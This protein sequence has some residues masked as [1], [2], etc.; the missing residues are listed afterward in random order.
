MASKPL[1][2]QRVTDETARGPEPIRMG[3]ELRGADLEGSEMQRSSNSNMCTPPPAW[4]LGAAALLGVALAVAGCGGSSSAGVAHLSSTKGAPSASS[5]GGGTSPDST[6]SPQQAGLAFSKCMRSNGVPS[7]PDP[8]PGGGLSLPAG[9]NP[10]APAFRAAQAKCAK[11]IPGGG[12]PG[13][14]STTHPSAQ[15]LARFL[16]VARCMRQ[17]G[18]Y[19]FPEPRTSVPA[20]PFGSGGGGVISDIE[21]VIFIFPGTI[22]MQSAAFT[23]AAEECAFPLHNH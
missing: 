14:G 15:V 12:P 7:F 16:K 10:E 11:L 8:N 6:E 9:V 19:D 18:I 20:N 2:P 17:H 22:D 23:H 13:P 5:G 1:V 3:R 4:L 21:E